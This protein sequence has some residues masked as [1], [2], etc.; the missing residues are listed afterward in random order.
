[1]WHEAKG[2][3][4]ELCCR[5]L[6]PPASLDRDLR[7][8]SF[9]PGMQAITEHGDFL[10]VLC[11]KVVGFADVLAEMVQSVSYTHLTLPTKA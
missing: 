2:W 4:G 1:M 7:T 10:W 5:A 3:Q 8:D 6:L 11:G 9:L